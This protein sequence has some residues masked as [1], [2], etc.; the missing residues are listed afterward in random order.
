M[1]KLD[2][3]AGASSPDGFTPM[4]NAHGTVIYPLDGIAD[5]S[6]DVIRASHVLEHFPM[7]DVPNVVKHWADK[8]KPGGVLKIAVPDFAWIAQ[9]YIDGKVAPIEGYTLGGQTAPDDFHRS[10]FDARTL[11]DLFRE[12]GLTDIGPWD[13]DNQDCSN[14][15]VS[16]NLR[17]VKPVA[18][19]PGEFRIAAAM[20]MPR[21]GFTDNFMCAQTALNKLGIEVRPFTGAFWGQCLE[22]G[23]ETLLAEGFEAVL[24]IDYD[25]VFTAQNVNSL[26][27]LMLLHPE[28]DAICPLQS[29]RGWSTPLMTMKLPDGMASDKVP[30]THFDDDLIELR[31]GHFGLTLIRAT[32]LKDLPKPWFQATPAPDGS[33]GDGRTDEDIYFWRQFQ[34]AGKT[35]FNANRVV[36]G[37][38]ELM[39]K[40]PGRDLGVIHQRVVDFWNQG[41]PKDVWK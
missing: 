15:P 38:C 19:I 34:S 9:A 33:W 26:I 36:V 29:A 13:G 10:L 20:S 14:L 1:L 28:A 32:A 39:V 17:A 22:R 35:L 12:A 6:V 2:L 4:G 23:I 3:G 7:A 11:A 24:V 40:W 31:T 30:K 16:L 8:L 37:H 18:L 27:R 25:T 5:A 41:P 21:L